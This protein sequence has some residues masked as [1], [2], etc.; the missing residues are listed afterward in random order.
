MLHEL[1]FSFVCFGALFFLYAPFSWYR[2][3]SRWLR[4]GFIT[5]AVLCIVWNALGIYLFSHSA[6]DD[7][8]SSSVVA[9]KLMRHIKTMIAGVAIGL[10]L[11]LILSPEARALKKRKQRPNKSQPTADPR[12]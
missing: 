8:R 4:V 7:A 6:L 5:V 10:V 1:A 2:P 3:G 9:Y 11:A 12:V